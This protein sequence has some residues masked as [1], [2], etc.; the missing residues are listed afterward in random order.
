MASLNFKQVKC[1][2]EY[3]HTNHMCPSISGRRAIAH[4]TKLDSHAL[5]SLETP[6]VTIAVLGPM[7]I[8]TLGERTKKVKCLLNTIEI[9]CSKI[10]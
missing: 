2:Y 4:P 8:H 7:I 3:T 5:T 6:L 9:K 1:T 10:M